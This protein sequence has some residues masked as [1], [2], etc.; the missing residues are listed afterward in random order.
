[1]DEKKL[2]K[3]FGFN[4][5]VARMKLK[6]TQDDIVE[7]ADLSNSY[8][9]NIEGGKH[10]LS[11]INALKLSKIVNKTIEELISDT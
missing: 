2:L 3:N 1:M 10:N 8:L 5:K 11:L 9:S 7:M 6:L 4:F